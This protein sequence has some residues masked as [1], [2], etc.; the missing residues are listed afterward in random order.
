MLQHRLGVDADQVVD[1]EFETRQPHAAGGQLRELERQRGVAHVEHELDRNGRQFG[2]AVDNDLERQ[3]AVIH[4]A[5]IAFGAGGGNDL[6]FLQ[7][8][9]G[10]AAAD[11]GRDAQFARDDGGVAGASAAIGDDGGSASSLPAPSSGRSCR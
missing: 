4:E 1:D 10:V 7:C 11:D 9:G 2:F 3:F 5:G 6:A 8:G